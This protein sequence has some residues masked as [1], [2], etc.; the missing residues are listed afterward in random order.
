MPPSTNDL[1]K[2]CELGDIAAVR[3]HIASDPSNLHRRK[4]CQFPEYWDKVHDAT[5]LEAAVFHG[6]LEVSRLL[7]DSGAVPDGHRWSNMTT[8]HWAAFNGHTE[9]A[10]LLLERGA[11]IAYRGDFGY[12]P[13]HVAADRGHADV[14][15]VLLDHGADMEVMDDRG[16]TPLHHAAFAGRLSLA[17][18][19]VRRGA[20][21]DA[22]SDRTPM[23]QA[24][25][26]RHA[27]V[28]RW[29]IDVGADVNAKNKLGQYGPPHGC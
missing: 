21:I 5:P 27:D 18:L 23:Q 7:L 11:V 25:Y 28:V 19:L 15:D 3:L 22:M 24:A 17:Q 1:W 10:R 16:R 12:S 4:E 6:R 26:Q 8:V 2:S 13:L 9:I 29:L 20:I 14:A